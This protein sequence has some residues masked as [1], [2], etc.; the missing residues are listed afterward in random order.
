MALEPGDT[1]KG[2]DTL[3]V[4]DDATD[5]IITEGTIIKDMEIFPDE[6]IVKMIVSS[7]VG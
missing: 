7:N 5:T 3:L 2:L 1:W 4:V 6:G